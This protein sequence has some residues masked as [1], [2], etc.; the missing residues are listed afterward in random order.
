MKLLRVLLWSQ[1]I[2]T[3]LTALWPILHIRSFMDVTG[4]KTDIWLVK[5]VGALLIPISLT[6]LFFVVVNTDKRPI[7]L[8]ASTTAVAFIVI[9]LYYALKDV[10]PDIYLADAGI[11]LLF[12]LLWMY[13][14][15]FRWKEIENNKR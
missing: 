8:L 6:I 13:I 11:E 5:T 2:Y 15:A 12:L 3:L 1:G 14:M 4:Y 7:V 9:D 10:I